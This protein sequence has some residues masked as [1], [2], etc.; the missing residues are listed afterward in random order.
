MKEVV[1]LGMVLVM[2][3]GAL[4]VTHRA[5]AQDQDCIQ[6]YLDCEMSDCYDCVQ[7]VL[8]ADLCLETD[9]DCEAA[10]F[11]CDYNMPMCEGPQQCDESCCW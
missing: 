3:A 4:V 10:V 1:R 5:K 11:A 2:L 6:Q 7:C 9:Q 8:E